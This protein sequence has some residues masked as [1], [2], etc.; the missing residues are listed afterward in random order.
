[1]KNP[2]NCFNR[3]TS[4]TLYLRLPAT[5]KLMPRKPN[6][7]AASS[8]RITPDVIV[9]FQGSNV[10]LHRLGQVGEDWKHSA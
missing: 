3:I 9:S 1:M 2:A 10:G 5:S 7:S 4:Q 6:T 8:A